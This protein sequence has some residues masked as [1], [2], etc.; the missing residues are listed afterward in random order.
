MGKSNYKVIHYEVKWGSV[1]I[2]PCTIFPGTSSE[3]TKVGSAKCKQCTHHISCD[4]TNHIVTCSIKGKKDTANYQ[5]KKNTLLNKAVK[6]V[7]T[8]VVYNSLSDAA[9]EYFL[10]NSTIARAIADNRLVKK[11]WKFE[12]VN[13]NL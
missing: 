12:Y 3:R 8:G 9:R 4:S 11:K 1:C 6:C 10:G 13:G 5:K 7:N 2:T